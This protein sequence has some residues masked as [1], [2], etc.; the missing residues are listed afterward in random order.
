MLLAHI[1]P[2]D[3]GRCTVLA[4]YGNT[5]THIVLHTSG[6]VVFTNQVGIPALEADN[7]FTSHFSIYIAVFTVVFP[8]TRPA[9]IASEVGHRSIRPRDASRLCLVSRD[10]CPLT[11]QFTIEGSSH[12]DALREESTA[13]RIGSSMYLVY[14]IYTRDAHHFHG[15]LLNAFDDFLPLLYT[16]CHTVGDVQDGAY[17]VF[18]DDRVKHRL[19]Q[20]EAFGILYPLDAHVKLHHHILRRHLLAQLEL[21]FKFVSLDD[22]LQILHRNVLRVE[23]GKGIDAFLQNID[24][25]FAH[26]SD[27]LVK[28]HFLQQSLNLQFYCLVSWN[29]RRN[30]GLRRS[31]KY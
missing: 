18:S 10:A 22:F 11:R 25:E 16:L 19:V 29:G 7:G 24:G 9:R 27:L 21:L 8:H 31:S 28:R 17:F 6:N 13:Q 12:V 4:G 1:L 20:L 3:G 26:L 23:T 15:F 14:A 5:I 2:G 30:S